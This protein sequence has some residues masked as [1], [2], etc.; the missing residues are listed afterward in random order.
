[1]NTFGESTDLL[2]QTHGVVQRFLKTCNAVL[3]KTEM[4]HLAVLEAHSVLGH[5]YVLE[6]A[7]LPPRPLP[8]CLVTALEK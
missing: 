8:L 1:M 7:K 6:T 3:L 4:Q 2:G 5:H